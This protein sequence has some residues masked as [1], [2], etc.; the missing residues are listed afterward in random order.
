VTTA[1]DLTPVWQEARGIFADAFHA[2]T[3][4]IVRT[5]ETPDDSGGATVTDA[6]VETGR[7]VL[8]V[9]GVGGGEALAGG[10]VTAISRYTAELPY[11]SDVTEADTLRI[12]GRR[13]EVL[14]AK[15]GGEHDLFTVV[16]L[17][18]RT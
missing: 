5:V 6:V 14:D 18:E 4:E 1:D 12:N 11:E 15:R 10:V 17:E 16:E 8:A 9:S 3:Y 7:C 2:D 13:F